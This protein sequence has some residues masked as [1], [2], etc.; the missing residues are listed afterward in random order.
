MSRPGGSTR[1]CPGCP[2]CLSKTSCAT[3][4]PATSRSR[5]AFLAANFKELR[6]PAAN[7]PAL[8]AKAKNRW[9]VPGPGKA[10]DLE[11]RRTAALLRE[12]EEYRRSPQRRLD[13]FRFEAVRAGFF[14]AWREQDYGTIIQVAERLPEAV[15]QE[16]PML[17]LWHDQALTRLGA[18]AR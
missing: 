6:N 12:F 18:S 15:L 9:H 2:R 10:A 16:D 17:L 7:H 13:Y 8:R 3:T 11:K 5:S 4:A 1:R 14:E